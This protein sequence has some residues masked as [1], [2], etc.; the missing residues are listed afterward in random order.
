MSMVS[1]TA[2]SRDGAGLVLH[3]PT[4]MPQAGSFLWNAEM[5]LQM[6]CRG[7]ATAQ[8][9]QPEPAKY[10]RGPGLEAT[11]FMQPEHPYFSHHSGRF[12]YVKDR[13]S[14]RFFSAPYEPVR[15][16]V[17][18]F[19]FRAL[20]HAMQWRVRCAGVQIDLEL[21]LPEKGVAELWRLKVTNLAEEKRDLSVYPVFSFGFLSWM[22]QS[23]T[24]DEELCAVTASYVTPYQ[25]VAD[26]FKHR[27]FREKSFLMAEKKPDAWCARLSAFEGEGGL[28][29]PDGISADVLGCENAD[30]EIPVAAMQYDLSLEPGE[31]FETCFVFGPAKDKAELG[32]IRNR[33]FGNRNCFE[34]ACNSGKAYVENGVG[35]L[36]VSTPDPIFDHYV[37]HWMAR[38]IHYH[39][40][41]N[42]L[43]TDPQTRNLLQDHMGMCLVDATSMKRAVLLALSQQ[44]ASGEMPDG[45]LLHPEA[46]LKYIN[47]V[48][49][50]DHSI[51]LPICLRAYLNETGDYAL[52][53]ETIPY[54]DEE[55]CETVGLHITKAMR[56]VAANRDGRGLSLIA[57]GD[58]CDPMNM[59]GYKG[60]GVSGWLTLA[61][62]YAF[63]EWAAICEMVGAVGVAT[64]MKLMAEAC[65]QAANKY[66]WDG[67]WYARG[68]TDDGVS[69]GVEKD[70]EGRIYLNPQS[71]A[72]LSG[73]A[74]QDKVASIVGEIEAQLMTPYGVM[75]LAPAY[76]GMREDVGR[77]TQKFPG[78]AENGSVYNHAAAFYAHSLY[79]IGES[80]RAY[81]VL[82]QMLPDETD[83]LRRGQLP[84]YIP[85][86]YR[87]AYHQLPRTAGRSSQLF[88]TG[89]VAWFGRIV[90][91]RLFGLEGCKDGLKI[92]PSLPSGWGKACV[93]RRFRG[94]EFDV[95]FNRSDKVAE[96]EVW[97][98]GVQNTEQV[99]KDIKPGR[100]YRIDVKLPSSERNGQ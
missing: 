37:N 88:N 100:Q 87:G 20:P 57:E 64:E 49:H 30:Y 85:N 17:D 80:D 33:F 29:S 23:G 60:R 5:M 59:V 70:D 2:F 28:H 62:A 96:M 73:A 74:D 61:S 90:V 42:R 32:A 4:E 1:S 22:N 86:Y 39:G 26:Y 99:V 82:R 55:R 76:T 75:M 58:W 52:L 36:Q 16:E 45:I 15:A 46:T 38:Q 27:D 19:E 93:M 21:A 77:L 31:N 44:K 53:E 9:M 92:C 56:W 51:W 69:F 95:N 50:T 84:V 65:N 3:S 41:T 18:E 25:K 81:S 34:D 40:A 66:I 48:P 54:A 12:F 97:V 11:T 71:W 13:R 68:I 67:K 78:S 89:T 72:I 91:E 43:S 79:N 6:T 94:A 35:A 83:C 24:Y 47:Q 98:D 8:F 63:Q 10:S 7:F 14:G